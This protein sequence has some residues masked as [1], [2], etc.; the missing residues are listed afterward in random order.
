MPD[1]MK[2]PTDSAVEKL[3]KLHEEGVAEYAESIA[4]DMLKVQEKIARGHMLPGKQRAKPGE[5]LTA[6][7]K[8]IDRAQGKVGIRPGEHGEGGGITL[9]I[10]YPG[11]KEKTIGGTRD[12]SDAEDAV[13]VGGT[14]AAAEKIERLQGGDRQTHGIVVTPGDG[15]RRAAHQRKAVAHATRGEPASSGE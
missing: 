3:E 4:L 5:M 8:I 15:T 9:V 6:S 11:Q 12:T 14:S 2:E 13:V 10:N 1:Y 7:E